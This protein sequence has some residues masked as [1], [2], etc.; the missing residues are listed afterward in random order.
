M[1][2]ERYAY[3]AAHDSLTGP[4]NRGGFRDATAALLE[5]SA[6]AGGPIAFF[7]VDF[8]RFKEVN[9]TLGHPI[10]DRVLVEIAARLRA[11]ACEH[12]LIARIGGD[13]FA[14]VCP[15]I[16]AENDVLAFGDRIVGALAKPIPAGP[17]RALVSGSIGIAF[18]PMHGETFDDVFANADRA[19]YAAKAAGRNC[20][21]VFRPIGAIISAY[22][23]KP[24]SAHNAAVAPIQTA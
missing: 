1:D 24:L 15:S 18:S 3:L 23:L 14:I 11:T 8:D 22:G 12:D 21:R 16:G 10:G 9:D 5:T 13:E 20:V 17:S 2:A 6:A 4:L 19:M 7:L